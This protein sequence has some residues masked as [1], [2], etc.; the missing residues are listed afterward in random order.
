MTNATHPLGI[1]LTPEAYTALE[2]TIWSLLNQTPTSEL[3]GPP[4]SDRVFAA[5]LDH[6]AKAGA[7]GEV[8]KRSF[9]FIA[10]IILVRPFPPFYIH[11]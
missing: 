5:L 4:T 1:P 7:G 11:Y 10:R 8:K 2:P 3:E 9:E 6:F